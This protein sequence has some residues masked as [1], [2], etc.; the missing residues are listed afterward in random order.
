[1]YLTT[2]EKSLVNQNFMIINRKTEKEESE[3]PM[4][5]S[6]ISSVSSK[7]EVINWSLSVIK[8]LSC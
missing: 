3:K 2:S 5:V 4:F 6:H 8:L 7:N 1:M